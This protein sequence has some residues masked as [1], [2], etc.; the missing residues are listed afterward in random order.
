MANE[1]EILMNDKNGRPVLWRC[2][3]CQAE[4]RNGQK[5][6][7]HVCLPTLLNLQNPRLSTPTS[8]P[9][10]SQEDQAHFSAP[11]VPY[12]P[13]A[14]LRQQ[15]VPLHGYPFSPNELTQHDTQGH[16]R[17]RAP[18][19]QQSQ[20]E[21]RIP[22]NVQRDVFQPPPQHHSQLPLQSQHPQIHPQMLQWQQ[23][24]EHRYQE[25]QK[26][27]EEQQKRYEEQQ[28]LFRQQ[29]EQQRRDMIEFQNKTF[30]MMRADNDL[31][32]AMIEAVS[33]EKREDGK[34]TKCPTW[35]KE[36]PLKKYI[37]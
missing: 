10:S 26:R 31:K 2:N 17:L 22:R 23:L 37:P 27:Q 20:S 7:G 24:Q 21:G 11:G 35:E 28:E 12:S 19:P 16:A 30:E 18:I 13:N 32:K 14:D 15:N 29:Q 6:R 25:Q 1:F 36:E 9:V 33:K 4:I 3:Q 5:P 34:R 8:T